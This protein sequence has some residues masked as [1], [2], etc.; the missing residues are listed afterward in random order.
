M[1]LVWPYIDENKQVIFVELED[2]TLHNV[3]N[4]LLLGILI[5]AIGAVM[6]AP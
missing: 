4:G 3:V 2:D 6:V 5:G 1:Q